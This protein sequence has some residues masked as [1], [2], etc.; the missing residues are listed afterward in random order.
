VPE[1][2][3]RHLVWKTAL[4][5]EYDSQ[6]SLTYASPLI[7]G[8][9]LIIYSG[10]FSEPATKCV[11]AIDKESG[12]TV[13]RAVTDFA[14]MSSPIVV[15]AAAR[16]LIVWSQQ[17]VTSLDAATGRSAGRGHGPE[18]EFDLHAVAQGTCC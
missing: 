2:G 1:C 7:E 5:K 6:V 10:R 4:D 18:S 16:Q 15:S 8:D 13:W 17:A 11:I 12:K 9:L 3:G 14:A